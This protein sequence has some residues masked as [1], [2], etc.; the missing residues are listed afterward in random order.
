MLPYGERLVNLIVF[1]LESEEVSDFE[2]G[3]RNTDHYQGSPGLQPSARSLP[4]QIP[5]ALVRRQTRKPEDA[6]RRIRDYGPPLS[7]VGTE[8]ESLTQKFNDLSGKVDN[9]MPKIEAFIGDRFNRAYAFLLGVGGLVAT[10]V[11]LLQRY[12]TVWWS[13]ILLGTLS[14]VCLIFALFVRP[15]R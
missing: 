3:T 1:Q 11:A 2:Y 14:L 9:F 15:R 6:S 13:P 5:E 8:I 12:E 4:A 10:L 7:W